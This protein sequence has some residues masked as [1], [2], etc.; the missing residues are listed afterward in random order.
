MTGSVNGQ[1]NPSLF[2]WEFK[3]G[4]LLA[5][6]FFIYTR[7]IAAGNSIEGSII[8]EFE[9]RKVAPLVRQRLRKQ[10]GDELWV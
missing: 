10:I 3:R 2:R 6:D 9:T 1:N 5:G 8:F 4:I 7:Q